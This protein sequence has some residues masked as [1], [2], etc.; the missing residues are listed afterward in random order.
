MQLQ[1]LM[2]VI[3]WSTNVISKPITIKAEIVSVV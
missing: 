1:A 2:V 3:I